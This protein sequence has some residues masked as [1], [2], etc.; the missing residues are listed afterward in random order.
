MLSGPV[1]GDPIRDLL[2]GIGSM[3][4]NPGPPGSRAFLRTEVEEAGG[5]HEEVLA[6]VRAHGGGYYRT[7]PIQSQGL[8]AG[9]TFTPPPIPSMNYYS[10]PAQALKE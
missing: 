6:W 3:G 7:R 10:V 8:R 1:N 4:M 9:R 2:L 5:D